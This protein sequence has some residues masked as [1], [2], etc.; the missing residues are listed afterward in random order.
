MAA[1]LLWIPAIA[2]FTLGFTLAWTALER[3]L[4]ALALGFLAGGLVYSWVRRLAGAGPAPWALERLA[5]RLAARRGS[6]SA[7]E[8]SEAAGI[9]EDRAREV[10]D[11]LHQRGLAE[12]SGERYTFKD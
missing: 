8:L 4:P 7:K 1:L 11:E 5:M 12:R 6:V 10:L 3:P 9:P 2:G